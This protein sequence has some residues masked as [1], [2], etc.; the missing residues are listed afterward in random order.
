M[1]TAQKFKIKQITQTF[2]NTGVHYVIEKSIKQGVKS[3][4]I[5]I[6]TD[7]FRLFQSEKLENRIK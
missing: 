2:L 7:Y 3:G 6:P 4:P 5:Y 1:Y